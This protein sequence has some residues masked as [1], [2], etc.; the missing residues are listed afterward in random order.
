MRT[1]AKIILI[2]LGILLY[3]CFENKQH[4]HSKEDSH[5]EHEHAEGELEL[6]QEQ[7]KLI[8]IKLGKIEDTST[9]DYIKTTGHIEASPESLVNVYA[10]FGG[11]IKKTYFIEGELVKKGELLA[12]VEH[13]LY[14][15]LQSKYIELQ[16]KVPVKKADYQRKEK[17]YKQGIVSKSE[18]RE[19]Q[20]HYLTL[21]SN[22]DE[23]KLKLE[24]V[25]IDPS[26]LK[27]NKIQK[28]I[29]LFAP[30]SG[31]IVKNNINVGKYISP[32][33]F[34][35]QILDKSHLHAEIQ[36]FSKDIYKIKKNMRFTFKV[37]GLQEI[38]NGTIES[39]NENINPNTLTVNVH[40]HFTDK[41]NRLKR[42]QYFTCKIFLSLK[43]SKTLPDSA[44]IINKDSSYVFI[45]Q[46]GH[47]IKKRVSLGGYTGDR[48]EVKQIEGGN[49]GADVVISGAY[50][51]NAMLFKQSGNMGHGHAH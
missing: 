38:F 24:A 27:K 20:A 7:L 25:G 33:K 17:L 1:L 43:K 49:F 12:I 13:P 3:N 39:I 44:V 6:T 41:R 2:V 51:L 42:N 37:T 23:I 47:F 8:D 5:Q 50:E 21:I 10:L 14:L 19:I 31:T 40:G 9:G 11:F 26:L 22:F 30:V 32:E 15:D 28:S 29:R 46:N 18:F 34:A 48:Y 35:L 36:V 4:K 16:N 45:K